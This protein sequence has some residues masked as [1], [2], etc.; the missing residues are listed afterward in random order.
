MPQK[1]GIDRGKYQ[2]L[3]A[4]VRRLLRNASLKSPQARQFTAAAAAQVARSI[5]EKAGNARAGGDVLTDT[6]STMSDKTPA[7]HLVTQ[8][9]G[10]RKRGR[11]RP[12]AANYR[13]WRARTARTVLRWRGK[14]GARRI[15]GGRTIAGGQLVG[16]SV[17]K[18]VERG[19]RYMRARPYWR[20]AVNAGR[21][22]AYR[23]LERGLREMIERSVR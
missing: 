8:L 10:I 17:A 13:E 20:A 7:A 21:Y 9:A 12:Y 2:E 22:R 19:T 16:M 4:N 1:T 11:S 15:A 14:R 6:F 18:M 3:V 23:D 5:R